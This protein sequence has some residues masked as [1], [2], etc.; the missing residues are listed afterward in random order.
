MLQAHLLLRALAAKP[1]GFMLGSRSSRMEESTRSASASCPLA[2]HSHSAS[3][4]SS[5][6]SPAPSASG[7]L[8]MELNS[9]WGGPDRSRALQAMCT[10]AGDWRC[11]RDRKGV[12]CLLAC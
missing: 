11:R 10:G 6:L 12:R 5:C 8:Q 9:S 7:T 4:S 3:A 2:R 1:S